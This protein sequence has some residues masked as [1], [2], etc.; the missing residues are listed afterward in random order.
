MR[1]FLSS[2]A[3][4]SFRSTGPPPPRPCGADVGVLRPES[5]AGEADLVDMGELEADPSWMRPRVVLLVVVG[6]PEPARGSRSP[7][8]SP[9]VASE[10]CAG[11]T[12]GAV[13]AVSAVL[14]ACVGAAEKS[15]WGCGDD[16]GE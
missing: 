11:G 7:A 16:D 10:I 13:V 9:V 12:F 14:G 4:T 6:P 5:G 8:P 2:C 1:E 3:W 15:G